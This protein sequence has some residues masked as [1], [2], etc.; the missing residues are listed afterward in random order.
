MWGPFCNDYIPRVHELK[1]LPKYFRQ[2]LKGNKTFELRKDDRNYNAGDK[3]ILKEFEDER[4][5]GCQLEK[6]ITYVFK[7]GQYGLEKGYVILAIK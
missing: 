7:G 5:T 3:L 2:V 6:T 4:F 1:I